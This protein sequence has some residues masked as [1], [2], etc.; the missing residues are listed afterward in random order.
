MAVSWSVYDRREY[1]NMPNDKDTITPKGEIL[2]DKFTVDI[3]W[4]EALGG[5]IDR[6]DKKVADRIKSVMR[7]DSNFEERVIKDENNK[8][9]RGFIR[10][11]HKDERKIESNI[12]E[13]ELYFVDDDAF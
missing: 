6:L 2:R 12:N 4:Q 8:P 1:C 5:S 3:I 7:S 11:G 13:A 10:K 9:V